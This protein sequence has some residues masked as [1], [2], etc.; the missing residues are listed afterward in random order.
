VEAVLGPDSAAKL[1]ALADQVA[2]DAF[3]AVYKGR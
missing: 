3:L 2:S 1:R